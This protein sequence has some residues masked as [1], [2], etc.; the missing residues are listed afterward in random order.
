[1]MTR[2]LR[3][4]IAIF[5]CSWAFTFAVGCAEKETPPI[6]EETKEQRRLKEKEMMHREMTN[7]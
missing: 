2:Y 4:F 7:Q 6:S 3:L 5:C 1:M